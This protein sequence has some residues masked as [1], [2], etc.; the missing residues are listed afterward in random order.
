[1]LSQ[2]DERVFMV[3]S[4]MV[5]HVDV[6]DRL[7]VRACIVWLVTEKLASM[8][9]VAEVFGVHRNTV[10]NHVARY[11]EGGTAG[12]LSVKPRRTVRYKVTPDVMTILK[13]LSDLTSSAAAQ[14]IWERKGVIVSAAHVRRLR[15]EM[16]A[17]EAE[18]PTLL[19]A[20]ESAEVEVEVD[21]NVVGESAVDA[22]PPVVG[23]RGEGPLE[24][25]PVVPL[26]AVSRYMGMSLYYPALEALGLTEVAEAHFSLPRSER[27]GVRATFLSLFFLTVLGKPTI[28]GAKHLAR[29][30]F[31]AVIG[32]GV[33]SCVK[34]LRRKLSELVSQ[35]AATAFGTD[36][37]KR[38]ISTDFIASDDLYVDGHVK[39]YTG[40]RNIQKR[41]SSQRRLIA[42]G[43]MSYFVGDRRGRPLLMVS[44]DAANSLAQAMPSVV[45]AIR[46]VL[47]DAR[48]TLIFDRGGFDGHLFKALV[49]EYQM[50]FI[51]YERG[52]PELA[53]G[54]FTT[55]EA[56]LEGKA[57]TLDI[58]EDTVRI[59]ASGPWRRI[60]VRSAD[61]H[62]TPIL[63]SLSPDQAAPADVACA[64]FVRWRQEN[65]FKYMKQ[66]LGLDALVSNGVDPEP[67]RLV[68]NPERRRLSSAIKRKRRE[69]A[70]AES[71]VA[72]AAWLKPLPVSRREFHEQDSD[73][74]ASLLGVKGELDQLLAELKAAPRHIE[75]DTIGVA[76]ERMRRDAKDIIDRVKMTAYNAEEWTLDKL[77]SHYSNPFD[78][79]DLLRSFAR[80]PGEMRSTP[81][82]LVVTLCPPDIPAQSRALSGLCH[83]LNRH[84][85]VYP[86]TRIPV[87][88]RVLMHNQRAST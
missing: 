2:G 56:Q 45:G 34:T 5:R 41:W 15:G 36:L 17:A 65:C 77:R 55:C 85:P 79:R 48:L 76:A 84:G 14:V 26:R 12:L 70:A 10:A 35:R 51:T 73:A 32:T 64:I 25:A 74:V 67:D 68:P 7:A 24:P 16:A 18:Q 30:S 47:G 20:P 71:I 80:L 21:G 40:G 86:G 62:Q 19:A 13:D 59:G 66:H 38:W 46:N 9:R 78:V 81:D 87:R 63:T 4:L 8:A 49:S 42:P 28:E 1:M 29:D 61:G 3:G 11:R 44:D 37:A 88:Y 69:L 6:R 23:G 22:T 50:D 27:I 31:G 43:L 82:G 57:V 52:T 75:G 60:V 72:R 39:A 83:A 53:A 33:G 58:A 54:E